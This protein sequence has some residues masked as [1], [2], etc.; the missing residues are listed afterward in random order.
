MSFE[1]LKFII[2]DLYRKLC[3]HE[4]VY[5]LYEKTRK[6][7]IKWSSGVNFVDD[8]LRF[9]FT[10]MNR[11]VNLRIGDNN[12]DKSLK[13]LKGGGVASLRKLVIMKLGEPEQI[14]NDARIA[15]YL[16]EKC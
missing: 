10:W 14:K 9:E 4:L 7:R 16:Q 15:K 12:S 11:E 3:Y 6:D 1:R 13:F 2:A 5:C 8:D